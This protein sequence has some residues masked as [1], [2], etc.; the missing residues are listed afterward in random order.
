MKTNRLRKTGA[1]LGTTAVVMGAAATYGIFAEPVRAQQPPTAVETPA[2]ATA[3]PVKT[4]APAAA[5]TRSIAGSQS[6]LSL[7]E[8]EK[9]IAATG[10][11]VTELEVKDRVVEVEGR[12]GSNREIEFLVDRRSGEILSRKV[13][14]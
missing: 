6:Y 1:V 13:D 10:V 4:P 7:T 2:T 12:D 8:I 3:A 9:R 14:D 5:V 11:K